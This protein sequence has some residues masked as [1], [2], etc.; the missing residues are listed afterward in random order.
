[1]LIFYVVFFFLI[2]RF[3]V[4]LFNFISNP[5]LP[6]SAIEYTDLVSILIPARNEEDNILNLLRSIKMQDYKNIEVIVLDDNS[7][8]ET[9]NICE[10]FGASDS[11]FKILK[12]QSLIEGWLG[13]NFACHQLAEAAKGKYLLFLDADEI[14]AD[15]L[16]NNALHRVKQGKLALLSL[17]TNQRMITVGERLV[18]PLMHFLLL[19]SLPL[20]LVRLSSN[21]ALSAA[22]GQFMLFESTLYHAHQ[23]HAQVK[24]KIVE[25]IEIMKLVKAYQYKAEA[26]LANGYISC[27]M[28]KSYTEAVD[29]FS[30]NLLAGFNY[31]IPGLICYLLLII[32]G[33]I[34]IALL[35]N[36]SL[37]FFAI[38]LIVLTRIMISLASGQNVL[39][40]LFLHPLQ[41]FSLVLISVISIRKYLTKKTNWKGRIIES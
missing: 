14:I 40:N 18:V 39:S 9:F 11:R 4:T 17:F 2:I 25:D 3:A 6:S 1:M 12:G 15:G 33:P 36:Y 21:P 27:R 30:K 38:S 41:M 7:S 26:L 20:R 13:K 16:I 8:D 10:K 34:F 28:Y 24:D 19:N 29:G 37:L 23:W 35:L 32:V 5:K 31:N 22:S